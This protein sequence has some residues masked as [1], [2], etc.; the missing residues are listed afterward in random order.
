MPHWP[1]VEIQ[2]VVLGSG[3]VVNANT[4]SHPDLY[5]ALKGGGNN[6]GVVTRFDFKTFEQGAFWGGFLSLPVKNSM[7]QLEFVQNF[8]AASGAGEDDFAAIESVHA[9]NA[10]G[11]TALASIITYTKPE[12]FPTIFKNL[13]SIRP[14]IGNDLRITNLS[15]LTAEA[16]AGKHTASLQ[17]TEPLNLTRPLQGLVMED[18]ESGFSPLNGLLAVQPRSY[19][20]ADT[21]GRQAHSQIMQRYSQRSMNLPRQHSAT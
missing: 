20:G 17:S 8:T 1:H 16:G 13:T 12:A 7:T 19:F 10:T 14:Q 11:Q 15:D 5:K 4:S 21:S 3:D 2:Q 9:Y 18:G 6:F